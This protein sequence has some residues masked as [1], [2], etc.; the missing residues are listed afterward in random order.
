MRLNLPI[1]LKTAFIK[2]IATIFN[3]LAYYLK[4]RRKTLQKHKKN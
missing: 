1:E 3:K 4:A 2:K